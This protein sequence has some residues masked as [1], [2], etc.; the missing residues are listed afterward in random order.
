M[1]CQEVGAESARSSQDAAFPFYFSCDPSTSDIF[2]KIAN[3]VGIMSLYDG[4]SFRAVVNA[5]NGEVG[6]ETV[7]HYHQDGNIVWA[8][9][10][11]GSIAKGSIIAV[12]QPDDSLDMRYHHVNV[13]GDLMTGRCRSVPERLDDGRLRMHETWQW[14]S[15]DQSSGQ[16]VIEE[17]KV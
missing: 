15:G 2:K 17:V 5:E 13:S 16:S 14:T 12:V 7:F 9:Y 8:E 11:G 3:T 10:S 4:K 6:S 1:E